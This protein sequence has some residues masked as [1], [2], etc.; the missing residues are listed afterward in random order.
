MKQ[1]IA[2]LGAAIGK[3]PEA[4]KKWRLR[5]SVPSVHHYKLT[6]A[7]AKKAVAVEYRDFFWE[8]SAA[9]QKRAP[10]KRRVS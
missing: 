9:N 2:E 7:A 6:Q 10:K 4:I 8:P 1:I 5:G 3:T